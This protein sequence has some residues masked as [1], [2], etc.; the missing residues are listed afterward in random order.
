MGFY[1]FRWPFIA[2]LIERTWRFSAA[3]VAGFREGFCTLFESFFGTKIGIL[4]LQMRPRP[5]IIIQNSFK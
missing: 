4:A 3:Q 5:S 2:F 1:R